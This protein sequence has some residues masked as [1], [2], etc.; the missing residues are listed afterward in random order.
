M[1]S[2][3]EVNRRLLVYLCAIFCG[4]F[5]I[6]VNMNLA[7][8]LNLNYE[9]WHHVQTVAILGM[10]G[11]SYR[12]GQ[13]TIL[14]CRLI[15]IEGSELPDKPEL[16]RELSSKH[17]LILE[18]DFK[19]MLQVVQACQ[20]LQ[21]QRCNTGNQYS[22]NQQNGWNST[23]GTNINMWT[24]LKGIVPGTKWCGLNDLAEN[25]HDLGSGSYFEVDKCCRAHDHCPVKVHSFSTSYGVTN[26]HP[27]TKS[28][29]S[30]DDLFYQCL[31][32][33][34]HNNKDNGAKDLANN[35]GRVYFNI[36][37][38]E[39][40]EA[41]Y[42]KVCTKSTQAFPGSRSHDLIPQNPDKRLFFRDDES[43]GNVKDW[44]Q[45]C[46]EWIVD[47]SAVPDLTFRKPK[48]LF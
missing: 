26:Y 5:L 17:K 36:F 32:R 3:L 41:H 47:T 12:T 19:T 22:C 15:L 1:K 4:L 27:Y 44:D 24:L 43:Q 20:D 33:I 39:C 42:P 31:K 9:V 13:R 38:L 23:A 25:Y 18:V 40:A 35:I 10:T 28:H 7:V 21:I 30:C 37:R 6:L 34:S 16:L 2:F 11:S 29:C 48:L 8:P 46:T 45:V 14:E